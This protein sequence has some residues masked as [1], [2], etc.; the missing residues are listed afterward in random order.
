MW[1][2]GWGLP[3]KNGMA[4]LPHIWPC[5]PNRSPF[6]VAAPHADD[7]DVAGATVA[8]EQMAAFVE[9]IRLSGKALE[10]CPGSAND[11]MLYGILHQVCF[12]S[13]VNCTRWG[14][15]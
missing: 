3:A 13:G 1:H 8:S 14:R 10:D 5:C 15:A 11:C 7:W 12:L 2:G 6:E 9:H 4:N